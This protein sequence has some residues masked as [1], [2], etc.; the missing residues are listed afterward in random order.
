VGIET[1]TGQSSDTASQ[2]NPFV[3]RTLGNKKSSTV[4]SS[5]AA[6]IP[7]DGIPSKTV[8]I[9]TITGQSSDTSSQGNPLVDN[10]LGNKKSTTASGSAAQIPVRNDWSTQPVSRVPATQAQIK[11]EALKAQFR[12]FLEK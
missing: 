3:D 10:T 6:Q 11:R 1:I 2:G 5:S 4:H 12:E 8:G 9:E 7:T